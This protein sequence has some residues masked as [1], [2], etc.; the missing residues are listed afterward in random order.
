MIRKQSYYSAVKQCIPLRVS[1][2]SLLFKQIWC[3][4]LCQIILSLHIKTLAGNLNFVTGIG[5]LLGLQR[6]QTQHRN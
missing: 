4:L 3:T 5:Y 2:E 1:A 6:R